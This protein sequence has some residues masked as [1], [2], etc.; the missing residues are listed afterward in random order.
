MR[1]S[2]QVITAAATFV[3]VSAVAYAAVELWPRK[4]RGGVSAP[5]V[6]ASPG[7]TSR[8]SG[9]PLPRFV[10][11]KTSKVN[12]RRGPS[13]QHPIAWAFTRRGLPVEITHE[14][15]HWRLVRDS[16]G[17]EGWIYHG[18]LSGKRT[19]LVAPWAGEELL[20]LQRQPSRRSTVVARLQSGVLAEVE[21]C[22][23]SWCQIEA[24]GR[25][26][27]VGQGDLWG[28]YPGEELR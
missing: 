22:D 10:S 27:W 25:T 2:L 21:G 17:D 12:V 8:Y 4:D 1:R 28:V 18:L 26:G 13:R 15:E 5:T 6:T 9:L 14:T 19:A 11:L 23:G 20:D 7:S 16:E 3:A 24:G